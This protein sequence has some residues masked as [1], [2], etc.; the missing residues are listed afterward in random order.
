MK[1]MILVYFFLLCVMFASCFVSYKIGH[2]DG[3][4]KA[5]EESTYDT[6]KV[7]EVLRRANVALSQRCRFTIE[8]AD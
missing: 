1:K 8:S 6:K 7:T 3:Y 2:A 4:V 5:S